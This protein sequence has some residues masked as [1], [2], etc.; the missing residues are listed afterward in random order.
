M[1]ISRARD[2]ECDRVLA[3]QHQD[4]RAPICLRKIRSTKL[5][6]RRF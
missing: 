5:P 6:R 3:V 2:G 1:A 4:T